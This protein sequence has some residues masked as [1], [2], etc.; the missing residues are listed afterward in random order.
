MMKD[1]KVYDLV[2]D[3]CGEAAVKVVKELEKRRNFSEFKLAEKI[4]RSINET[5]NILYALHNA[6]LASFIRKKDQKKGWYIYYWSFEPKAV[7]QLMLSQLRKRSEVL[8]TRLDSEKGKAFFVCENGCARADFDQATALEFKCPEC[9]EIMNP[10]EITE[11]IK[12][13]ESELRSAEKKIKV[14][15]GKPR[16]TSAG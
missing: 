5:R 15:S 13:R 1:K 6:S 14:L 9:G 8:K 4:D 12:Q 11:D 16:Q 3:V 2:K 7:K 10:E